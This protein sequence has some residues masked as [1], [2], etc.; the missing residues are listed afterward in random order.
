MPADNYSHRRSEFTQPTYQGKVTSGAAKRIRK[1]VDLLIQISPKVWVKNPVTGRNMSH[2]LSFI[3][4]TIP[5][6]DT[7]YEA[8]QGHQHL[9]EPFLRDMRRKHGMSTYIWKAE[10]QKNG[11]LHY[12]ITTRSVIPH[13]DIK[14]TWNN[15]LHKHHLLDYHFQKFGNIT[16]PSTHI[17]EVY[18]N[19][20]LDSYLQ[21][22]ISKVQRD[23]TTTGKVWDCSKNL[24]QA[25]HFTTSGNNFWQ[26][27]ANDI[28]TI[29]T[30][31]CTILKKQNPTSLLTPKQQADYKHHIKSIPL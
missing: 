18:K 12:H 5:E 17:K 2:T 26:P 21:K 19:K 1:A 30:P 15:L 22:E 10:F 7:K 11:M 16:P 28:E 24:K 25:K 29:T 8:S 31:H 9:L 23:K 13:H 20:K 3:T 4:L 14:D 6:Q 27:N